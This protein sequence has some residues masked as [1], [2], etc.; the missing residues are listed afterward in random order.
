MGDLRVEDL[1]FQIKENKRE[2][3]FIVDINGVI[4]SCNEIAAHMF[5]YSNSDELVNLLV[6][7][8]VPEDFAQL[9]PEE[10]SQEHLTLGKF[11][12]RINRKKNGELFA[13]LVKTR[14]IFAGSQKFVQTTVKI[15]G[16]RN[17]D[18][19]LIT[20][21]RLEQNIAVLKCE[22]KKEKNNSFLANNPSLK[23]SNPSEVPINYLLR[24]RLT[25][26][27]NGLN[28]N[29]FRLASL[30]FLNMESHEI[31]SI[32]NISLNSVYMAR[33]RLR[34]KLGIDKTIDLTDYLVDIME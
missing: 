18:E 3:V 27:H 22:L 28:K 12:Q 19:E 6:K 2:A 23:T 21:R 9:F 5:G 20:R 26:L 1:I 17:V 13:S 11:L 7:H 32:L 31:A 4:L 10:I 14:Y 33:K 24:D 15:D 29:D 8:L 25:D 16:D 34:K 30:L